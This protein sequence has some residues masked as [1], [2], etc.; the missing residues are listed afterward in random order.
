MSATILIAIST[1]R[2]VIVIVR[3]A[4]FYRYLIFFAIL[5][6]SELGAGREHTP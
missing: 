4:S 5:T 6:I 2:D 3:P 1:K